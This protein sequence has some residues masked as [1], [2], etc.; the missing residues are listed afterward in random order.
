MLEYLQIFIWPFIW[1]FFAV[2]FVNAI[3]FILE[4]FIKNTFLYYEKIIGILENNIYPFLTLIIA[5]LL[6]IFIGIKGQKI[7]VNIMA[8]IGLVFLNYKILYKLIIAKIK[9]KINEIIK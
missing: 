5:I 3:K 4:K 1:S 8:Y 9:N 6:A 7:G 2:L